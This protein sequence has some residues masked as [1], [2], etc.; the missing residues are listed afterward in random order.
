[1]E[2][3]TGT[4]CPDETGLAMRL[5]ELLQHCPR[6]LALDALGVI[7]F[8]QDA[9]HIHDQTGT[10]YGGE[11]PDFTSQEEA[12]SELVALDLRIWDTNGNGKLAIIEDLIKR[13][14]DADGNWKYT[15]DDEA[16]FPDET[17]DLFFCN[18]DNEELEEFTNEQSMRMI[19]IFQN[20]DNIGLVEINAE[21]GHVTIT[22]DKFTPHHME[23]ISQAI[24]EI[25]KQLKLDYT[26]PQWIL[27]EGGFL[28]KPPPLPS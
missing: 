25:R 26:F 12:I 23:K 8:H 10:V 4:F 27:R 14:K 22:D 28:S 6:Q 20:F 1:M 18:T 2:H 11:F 5:H 16:G 3:N 15:K 17:L 13:L 19:F 24:V 21:Y 7:G 9:F